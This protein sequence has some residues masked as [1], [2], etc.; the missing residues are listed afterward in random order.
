MQTKNYLPNWDNE[1]LT[2]SYIKMKFYP[3]KMAL[4]GYVAR[5]PFT[6]HQHDDT[7][8]AFNISKEGVFYCFK[9]GAKGN[10]ITLAKYFGD[11]L[12]QIFY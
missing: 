2:E 6:N 7:R 12:K 3:V 8:P 5:C 11:N 9:C 4:N 10:L 1:R